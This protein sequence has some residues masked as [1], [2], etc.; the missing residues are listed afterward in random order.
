[1]KRCLPALIVCLSLAVSAVVPNSV[2]IGRAQAFEASG[3]DA[4]VAVGLQVTTNFRDAIGTSQKSG[5]RI[6]T[7]LTDPTNFQTLA[8]LTWDFALNTMTWDI[9]GIGSTT[10]TLDDAKPTLTGS[11]YAL[12]YIYKN[13]LA[14]RQ[15]QQAED[16]GSPGS[17]TLDNPGCDWFPDWLETPCI[18]DCCAV[19]DACYA[20]QTPP[21]TAK[22][23]IPFVGSAACKACNKAV[24]KCIAKCVKDAIIGK[25]PVQVEER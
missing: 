21:C 13:T 25:I 3:S 2:P 20:A 18:L 24:V 1:M 16:T 17:G 12:Y 19:H 23:W 7:V 8:T 5:N 15:M 6:T 4:V 10:E 9:P 22:S 14:G 11:N